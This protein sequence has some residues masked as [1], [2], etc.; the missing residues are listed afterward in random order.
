MEMPILEHHS[1]CL[2]GVSVVSCKGAAAAASAAGS[3]ALGV[4]VVGSSDYKSANGNV[5]LPV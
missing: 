1:P 5:E 2:A 3:S 4:A